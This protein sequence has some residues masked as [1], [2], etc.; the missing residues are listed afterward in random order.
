M[1]HFDA[2]ADAIAQETLL[3]MAENFFG[4]RSS[5]DDEK[6]RF[7]AQA[8]I[9][10]KM[11]EGCLEKAALLHA[12]LMTDENIHDFYFLLDVRPGRYFLWVDPAKANIWFPFPF[13]LT[14]KGRYV[15]L[16]L[17]TYDRVQKAFDAY[18]NGTYHTI[19][20]SGQKRLS[21][22]FKLLLNWAGHIN[23]R[24]RKV[25]E[26][27]APSCVLGFAHCMNVENVNKERVSGATLNDYC[28]SLDQ[29]LEIAPVSCHEEQVKELPELPPLGDVEKVLKVYARQIFKAHK[30]E[31]KPMLQ[32]LRKGHKPLP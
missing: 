7:C 1:S 25:N 32:R 29:S 13:A 14:C 26:G 8:E 4:E 6:E 12:L 21:M 31:L 27:L 28:C 23:R 9:L 11:A 20:E 18:M 30:S 2:Y 10:R 3:E 19:P 5:I 17:R 16:L 22:H 24:I 15:K